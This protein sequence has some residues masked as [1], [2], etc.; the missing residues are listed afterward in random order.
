MKLNEINFIDSVMTFGAR[1]PLISSLIVLFIT[2]FSSFGLLQLKIDSSSESMINAKDKSIPIYNQI[3]KEF[4]SDNL[5]LIHYQHDDLFSTDKIKI[6]DEVSYALQNL[7]IV[8]K[9]ESLTTTLHIRNTQDGLE[10]ASLINTLPETKK[11]AQVIKENALYSPLIVGNQLS[12]DGKKAAIIVTLRPAFKKAKFNRQAYE[13][14]EKTIQPLYQNFDSVFQIG[15]PRLSVEFEE[16]MLSDITKITPLGGFVLFLS[17]VL[18]LRT[19]MAAFLPIITSVLS[20]IWTFGLL[21]Y[22]GIPI[23]LLTV[24]LPALIIVIGSTEDTHMLAVYLEA[25]AKDKARQRFPAIQFMARHVGLPVIITSFTTIIGFLA[26]AFSD[27]TLISHF[28]IGSAL[29]MFSNLIVTILVLPTLLKLFGSKKN[30]TNTDAKT[31]KRWVIIFLEF[32][33]RASDLHQKKIIIITSCCLVI[34]TFFSLQVTVSNDPLSFFKQ[35]SQI[36]ANSHTIHKN[37]AG[38]QVF[39]ITINAAKGKDFR[40]PSELKKLE[41]IE[42]FMK[43]QRVYDKTV[44]IN[45][46]LKLINQEIHESNPTFYKIPH[47]QA[48]IEQ[49]LMLFQR[50]DIKRVLSSDYRRVNIIVRHNLSDSAVLNLYLEQLSVKMQQL[51]NNTNTFSLTGKNLLINKAAESLFTSQVWSITI[52]IAIICVLMSIMYSSLTAGLVSLIPNLIP[53]IVMFGVMGILGISLN[54]GTAIVAVIAIGIAIDD[55]I[56]I[57]STYNKECRRDGNQIAAAKRAVKA[58]AIPVIATSL[59][60][61]AGFL[62]LSVS[63][64][65]IISQFGQLSALTMIVAMFSDLLITPILFKRIQLVSLL[66]V[67]TFKIGKEVLL[68]SDIFEGMKSYQIK[69]IILLSQM[70]EYAAG[71]TIIQQGDVDDKLFIVIAGHAD[72]IL[73]EGTEQEKTIA[74]LAAG[75]VF[76]EAGFVGGVTRT[77]TIRVP[78]TQ[79]TKKQPLHVIILTHKQVQAS[80]RFYPRLQAKLNYNICKILALHLSERTQINR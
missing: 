30:Q 25:I 54:P 77:A 28:G 23:N 9:V 52:L 53:V 44:S 3:I 46:Y 24:V 56:H 67:I 17:L 48:L 12:K 27:I 45:D 34:F 50:H 64:L 80:M 19:A 7:K 26:N 15:N 55:T 47:T 1:K 14:I 60:L 42:T 11:A 36:V 37:L 72:I 33:E 39:F 49:Y 61:A 13:L 21:G 2:I 65:H 10:I 62:I 57:L 8:E 71:K 35:D 22:F 79:S 43:T 51:L 74:H 31:K 78:I 75:D 5:I 63:T 18:M 38:I 70:R 68:K 4:G 6:V 29:G 73:Y 58:E 66:D 76:G 16:G 40:H 41:L 59:S 32:I 69:Q 20:I